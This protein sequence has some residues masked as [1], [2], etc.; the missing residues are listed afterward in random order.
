MP[1]DRLYTGTEPIPHPLTGE[2]ID[3][4]D[5]DALFKAWA[6]GEIQIRK[7]G[8]VTRHIRESCDRIVYALA[9]QDVTRSAARD[10]ARDQNEQGELT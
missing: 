9:G 6:D 2:L 3:L 8:A 5:R 1:V 4:G 7:N 10:F